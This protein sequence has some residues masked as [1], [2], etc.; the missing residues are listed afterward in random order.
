[1][2]RVAPALYS[3]ALYAL[4]HDIGKPIL[5]FAR[6]YGIE[7]LKLG[8]VADGARSVVER[9]L[10]RII[11]DIAAMKHHEI[12]EHIFNRLLGASLSEEDRRY[13]EQVLRTVDALAASERGLESVTDTFMSSVQNTVSEEV[14]NR[15]GLL[16]SYS[17]EYVP[18]LTPTWLL[19]YTGY[20]G[21]VGLQRI[22]GSSKWSGS[23]ARKDIAKSI[24]YPIHLAIERR[25]AT[26][27]SNS[28]VDILSNLAKKPLWLPVRPLLS[29]EIVGLTAYSLKEA[30]E[31]T[32]Y[33][34]IVL[35]LLGMLLT[36]RSMYSI[37]KGVSRGFV[38]TV[39]Y[40]LKV[41]A[42]LV[43]SAI[44]WSLIPDISLYSH[45]KLVTALATAS[46]LGKNKML[47]LLV[48]DAN[49]IQGFIA[50][51]IKAAAASRVI[52][53][54]SLLLELVMDAMADYALEVFGGLPQANMVVSEGGT[55]DIIVPEL[56]DFENRVNKFREVGF[57]LSRYLGGLVGFTIAYSK[58]FAS[59]EVSFHRS[60][61]V[62]SG[63]SKLSSFVDVLESVSH[64]FAVEKAR[65]GVREEIARVGGIIA[66]DDEV[67]G[68]DSLT[69][70]PILKDRD[71]L[72]LTVVQDPKLLDYVN[73]L[74]GQKLGVGDKIS[75]A[76]HLSLA[77]GT[78]ARELI[79][80]VSLH[81]YRYE[82]GVAV[83]DEETLET[84]YEDVS[85]VLGENA[86]VAGPLLVMRSI[87][88]EKYGEYIAFAP[89]K[90]VGALYI[91]VSLPL[92]I[93]G[94]HD[95]ENPVLVDP[96]F[97]GA[98]SVV[99]N[100]LNTVNQALNNID[101]SNRSV[102]VKIRFANSP[103]LFIFT[104]AIATLYPGLSDE[105][106]KR[107]RNSFK[108]LSD[109]VAKLVEKNIDVVLGFTF[110]GLYH[111]ATYITTEEGEIKD[112]KLVDL[113]EF[114]LIAVAKIDADQF[115]EIKS[116][117]ALSPSRLVTLSDL[118]N[119]IIAGKA[120]LNAVEIT[121]KLVGCEKNFDVIPLYAGGDDVTIYGKWSHVVYYLYKLVKDVRSAL[122]PLSLSIGVSIG[123]SKEPLLLLYR[124]AVYLLDEYAKSV[125]ASCV[126][127][128]PY[129]VLYPSKSVP[130]GAEAIYTVIPI[131]KPSEYY[132]WVQDALAN[133]NLAS[134]AKVLGTLIGVEGNRDVESKL[135]ELKRELYIL[136]SVA[137]EY[138]EILDYY[139]MYRRGA[140]S[141]NE[142][143][144]RL[145]PL[146]ILYAYI[147]SRRSEDLEKLKKLFE[148]EI[149]GGKAT[150]ILK[151][152]EEIVGARS[153]E[154]ALRLL[155]AAKP[156]ID[157][158]ILALRRRDAVEPSNLKIKSS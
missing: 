98:Y 34:E 130:G 49:N 59:E 110:L 80:I 45:S 131:E 154:E 43:P 54:R 42:S 150:M 140:I 52:R 44:Y 17:H 12:S 26:E 73:M 72:K 146:Q 105:T 78:T 50:A 64:R 114:G 93:A 57:E 2:S 157:L 65:I 69:G 89:L 66:K 156:I 104:D 29:K 84:V 88:R 75:T 81:I 85:K 68:F 14:R 82:Q 101:L 134:L 117:Y 1:M 143:K 139:E 111:P 39:E 113:E 94:I 33:S 90:P 149:E 16:Y 67:E 109:A 129:K 116:L 158:I 115:G 127:G 51:P 103:H 92:R 41:G 47:R 23:E 148:E 21:S 27:L 120:Y 119:T 147:W 71:P 5:R 35:L 118:V 106:V 142:Y 24:F 53:G 91:L 36:A 136:A 124:Y 152:P 19:L 153:V 62:L 8:N 7:G 133:W 137:H 138:E 99:R 83:P 108:S 107:F 25:D 79:A 132:R 38:D 128:A 11:N 112:I 76:T 77:I 3:L 125:R 126:I 15:A 95:V 144:A 74:S 102:R 135:E 55:I 10:G 22:G 20:V 70:E 86:D 40:I 32:S 141:I 145:L 18:L 13:F 96:L 46:Q 30:M 155:L 56:D 4:L 121:K 37:L 100:I 151:Y 9:A 58:P 97:E 123:D 61:E 122:P 63:G 28:L 87:A 6:R 48:I 60:V 31:R